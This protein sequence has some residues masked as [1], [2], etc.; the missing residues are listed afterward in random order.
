MFR[1]TNVYSHPRGKR[2]RRLMRAFGRAW[3]VPLPRRAN[4]YR[5]SREEAR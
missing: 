2:Y 4:P 5:Q 1:L 3:W